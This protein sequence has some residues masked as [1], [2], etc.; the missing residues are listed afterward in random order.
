MQE[1][2]KRHFGVLKTT[3]IGGLIFL[4]PLIVIGALLGQVVQIVL[5]VAEILGE[6]IPVD[7][8]EGWTLLVL[9]ALVFLVSLCFVAGLAARRSFAK[10]FSKKIE[11]KLTMFFPRYAIIKEQMAGSLGGD[12]IKP[13]LKPVIVTFD[14]SSRI[15]F[16]VDRTDDGRLAVYLPGAPDT[17]S[18][19]VAY[20]KAEQVE[21]LEIEFSEAMATFEKLGRESAKALATRGTAS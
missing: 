6:W 3:A 16:E 15:A 14:D 5:V 19:H 17:W 1:P 2:I 11:D 13:Q 12:D 4:L 9:L 10:R 21:P 20:L 18:G 7:T 8:V